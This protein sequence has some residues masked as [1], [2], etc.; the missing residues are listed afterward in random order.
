MLID[1]L[2]TQ[3]AIYTDDVVEAAS[4]GQAVAKRRLEDERYAYFAEASIV[5]LD[6]PDAVFRGYEGDDELL[7][8]VREDDISVVEALRREI[9]RLEPQNVYFPLAVGNHVDHQLCRDAGVAL[10]GEPRSWIMPAPE[11]A[12]T[13]VFY[14]DFPYAWWSSFDSLASLPQGALDGI[15]SEVALTPRYADI[16]EELERKIQGLLLYESQLERLFGG[17]KAM[18][19]TVR[20]AAARTGALGGIGV[21]AERYWHSYHP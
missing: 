5:F 17:A 21:A 19:S 4:A 16:S 2:P 20:Q 8:P 3:G 9:V 11:W 7:G 1:T 10:L 13:V 6:M 15:P 14:E 18:A 12:G